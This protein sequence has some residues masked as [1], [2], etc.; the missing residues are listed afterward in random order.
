MPKVT[1][2]NSTIHIH[3]LFKLKPNTNSKKA[4]AFYYYNYCLQRSIICFI[5]TYKSNGLYQH[6]TI[7]I[8]LLWLAG[9]LLSTMLGWEP[10]IQFW[11]MGNPPIYLPV[12]SCWA[13]QPFWAIDSLA[14]PCDLNSAR[15]YILSICI[16]IT[17]HG[18][19]F[20]CNK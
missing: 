10:G 17:L 3:F 11:I 6:I 4:N 13:K 1:A 20:P 8:T 9:A 16:C 7:I 5:L 14:M 12:I 2:I 18:F 19:T 15:K